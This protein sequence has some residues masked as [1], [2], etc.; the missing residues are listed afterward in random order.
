MSFRAAF[1]HPK[2]SPIFIFA[3]FKEPKNL[4]KVMV[5][6]EAK[7]GGGE[8]EGRIHPHIS[9]HPFIATLRATPYGASCAQRCGDNWWRITRKMGDG[10]ER[11]A[12]KGGDKFGPS[13]SSSSFM[14]KEH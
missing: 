1:L 12:Q 11:Q 10:D 4:K 7:R 3:S 6:G 5:S 8:G 14:L 2:S 13:S 9:P